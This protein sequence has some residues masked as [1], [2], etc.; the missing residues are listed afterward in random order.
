MTEE[1]KTFK[2][3]KEDT[4][5]EIPALYEENNFAG[6][7]E[8]GK[9]EMWFNSRQETIR[10]IKYRLKNCPSLTLMEIKKNGDI[11]FEAPYSPE[12]LIKAIKENK[13]DEK[14]MHE[15]LGI[16]CLKGCIIYG[17]TFFNITEEDLK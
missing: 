1:L 8:R 5:F 13:V 12:R 11:S 2:E 17:I 9:N 4:K 15:Y 16:E 14:L 6:G 10:W 3:I 7:Y